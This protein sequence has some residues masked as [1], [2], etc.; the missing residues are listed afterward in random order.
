MCSKND[1]QFGGFRIKPGLSRHE[2]QELEANRFAI[3]LLAPKSLV[4][5]MSSDEPSMEDLLNIATTLDLSKSSAARRYVELHFARVAV[6]F[7]Q[8]GRVLYSV[9]SSGC[10]RIILNKG[11]PLIRL[12]S[13][14]AKDTVTDEID[15]EVRKGTYPNFQITAYAETLYQQ[16]GFAMTLLD[17]EPDQEDLDSD[18][19]QE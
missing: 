17:F 6:V 10:P 16:G 1:V 3:E 19:D 4:E 2:V 8:H 12:H 18:E 15:L 13:I 11:D 7:T 9:T 5:R 14:A